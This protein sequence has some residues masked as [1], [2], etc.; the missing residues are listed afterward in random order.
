MQY[1]TPSEVEQSLKRFAE[2]IGD[3]LSGWADQEQTWA[4]C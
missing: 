2:E 1:P 4:A 3:T